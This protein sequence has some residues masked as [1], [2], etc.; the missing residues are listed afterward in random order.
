[1][2]P[3]MEAGKTYYLAGPMS[4]RPQF[5]VPLF[6][7]VATLL[8]AMDL[9]II[10]PADLDSVVMQAAALA[11]P[12]GDLAALEAVSKETWGEVLAR[13]VKI[14]ADQVEG[15]VL[16][17]DWMTSRGARLEAFVG[18]LCEHSFWLW[19]PYSRT[20]GEPVWVPNDYIRQNVAGNFTHD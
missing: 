7:E 9:T 16:L 4:G 5:N 19:I 12:D 14:V 17:P 13:D 20:Y 3:L 18:L 1:M 11:S 6:R 8:R 10:N 2:S 15:I